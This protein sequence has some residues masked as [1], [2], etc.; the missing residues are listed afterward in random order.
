MKVRARPS[1]WRRFFAFLVSYYKYSNAM[2]FL[3]KVFGY[4]SDRLTAVN[5]YA[6]REEH[7][8]VM[9]VVMEYRQG[10]HKY[11]FEF[12]SPGRIVE[13]WLSNL[14]PTQTLIE[15]EVRLGGNSTLLSLNARPAMVEGKEMYMSMVFGVRDRHE[16]DKYGH[17]NLE[18][19]PR[20]ALLVFADKSMSAKDRELVRN[21]L[22]EFLSSTSQLMMNLFMGQPK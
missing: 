1:S 6:K 22:V 12:H 10:K 5:S 16:F 7:L 8:D 17:T 3:H 13:D 18:I 15:R 14:L 9:R 20:T 19:A 2:S 11:I 21:E 4:P